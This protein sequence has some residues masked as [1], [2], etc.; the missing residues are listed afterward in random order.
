[1]VKV[2]FV[3]KDASLNEKSVKNLDLKTLHVKCNV[4]QGVLVSDIHGK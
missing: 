3:S 2:V 4:K 1:M